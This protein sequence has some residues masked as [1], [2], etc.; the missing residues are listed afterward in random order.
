ME[1]NIELEFKERLQELVG[2]YGEGNQSG[3]KEALNL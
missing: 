1:R 2:G 3:V